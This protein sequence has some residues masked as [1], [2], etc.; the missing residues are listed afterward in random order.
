VTAVG[1]IFA[2]GDIHGMS[3]IDTGAVY[4]NQLTCVELPATVFHQ[5]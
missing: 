5:V 3:P 1:N 2:V 4:G